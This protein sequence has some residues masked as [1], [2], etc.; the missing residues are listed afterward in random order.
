MDNY[1]G[2]VGGGEAEEEEEKEQDP[3]SIEEK[4]ILFRLSPLTLPPA[5][6]AFEITENGIKMPFMNAQFFAKA[7]DFLHARAAEMDLNMVALPE[8]IEDVF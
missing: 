8:K 5:D 7:V 6:K 2:T 4:E 3:Y 1:S